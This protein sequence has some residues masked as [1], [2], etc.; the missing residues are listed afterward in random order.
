MLGIEKDLKT[1]VGRAQRMTNLP[2]Q[3]EPFPCCAR[4]LA[5]CNVSVRG[6]SVPH[7]SRSVPVQ[8][9]RDRLLSWELT[10]GLDATPL[11]ARAYQQLS[12]LGS[13]LFFI[14]SLMVCRS[15]VAAKG[16]VLEVVS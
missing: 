5:D 13:G 2:V 16:G 15:V 12:G 3:R 10:K 6:P 7:S 14:Y 9:C 4:V 8:G 11:A 1:N